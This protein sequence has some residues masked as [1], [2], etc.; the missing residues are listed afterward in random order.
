MGWRHC[1]WPRFQ[2][3]AVGQLASELDICPVLHVQRSYC[4]GTRPCSV[5]DVC[6]HARSKPRTVERVL[7]LDEAERNA[8]RSLRVH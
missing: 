6:V 4:I 7:K 2:L 5:F 8:R 1:V 3:V